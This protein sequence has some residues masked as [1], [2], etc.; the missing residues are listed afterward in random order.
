MRDKGGR[1]EKVEN[2][3]VERNETESRKRGCFRVEAK[4]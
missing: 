2:S 1:V 3:P 4:G